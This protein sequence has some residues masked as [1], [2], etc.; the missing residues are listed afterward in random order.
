MAGYE[1]AMVDPRDVAA[2]ALDGIEQ[3]LT[4]VL[5]DQWSTDVKASLQLE[6]AENPFYAG[7]LTK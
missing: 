2:K 5:V 4:E 6:P 1:G 3:G 7:V